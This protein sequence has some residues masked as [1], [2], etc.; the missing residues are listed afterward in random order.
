[1]KAVTVGRAGRDT[2]TVYKGGVA[3]HFPVWAAKL[4]ELRPRRR[5]GKK[6]WRFVARVAELDTLTG[7]E[8]PA[9]LVKAAQDYARRNGME[10]LDG[11]VQGSTTTDRAGIRWR[12]E[13]SDG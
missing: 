6:S 12:K 13:N 2:A 4:Y 7:P 10:Y 5:D 1:M 8:P 9:A 3:L 11:V